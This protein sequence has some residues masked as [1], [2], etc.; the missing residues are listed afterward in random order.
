MALQTI[1]LQIRK[2]LTFIGMFVGSIC[3]FFIRDEFNFH[4]YKTMI[5]LEDNY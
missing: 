1:T 3:G 2:K 5:E 4:T